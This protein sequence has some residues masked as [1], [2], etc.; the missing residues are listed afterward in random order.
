MRETVRLFMRMQLCMYELLGAVQLALPIRGAWFLTS[1]LTMT[2]NR[3]RG[4]TLHI[5]LAVELIMPKQC[6]VMSEN[7]G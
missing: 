3:P 1:V 5:L 4:S 6:R 7:L 2:G